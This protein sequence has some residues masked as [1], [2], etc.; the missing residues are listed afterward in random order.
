MEDNNTEI[1]SFRASRFDNLYPLAYSFVINNLKGSYT[2]QD[3][4]IEDT[5]YI[6][7]TIYN[8]GWSDQE[9]NF[10]ILDSNYEQLYINS[11]NINHSSFETI[12][13]DLSQIDINSSEIFI[14]RV[15]PISNPNLS[16]EIN[17]SI[18]NSY[19][20]II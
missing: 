12:Q 5:E 11:I 16:Q 15:S 9:Y 1:A 3:Y 8:M 7:S 20:S 19:I 17:F 18:I 14:L 10:S 2:N 6:Q 4:Y 13:I